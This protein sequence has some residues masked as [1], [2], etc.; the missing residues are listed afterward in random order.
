MIAQWENDCISLS[1]LFTSSLG[2]ISG[3]GGVFHF[4]LSQQGRKW[5][6]LP[7][8]APYNL[9]TLRR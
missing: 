7:S 9:R 4:S 6:N 2:S 8:A 5:L 1:V 3:C